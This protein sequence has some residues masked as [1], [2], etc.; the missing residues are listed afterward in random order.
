MELDGTDRSDRSEQMTAQERGTSIGLWFAV[1][2]A[3]SATA[4]HYQSDA[5]W[6][7]VWLVMSASLY[8]I[9]I[10]RS[11]LLAL[12][13]TAILSMAGLILGFVF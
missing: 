8:M 13:S 7:A 5:A 6:F 12:L 11:F 3:A 2:T 4:A 10:D 9:Q 1:L